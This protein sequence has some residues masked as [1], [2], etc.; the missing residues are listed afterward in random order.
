MIVIPNRGRILAVMLALALA[1]GLLTLTLLAKPTQA[2]P[3]TDNENRGAG[4]HRDAIGFVID[5]TDCTGEL[6]QLTGTLHTADQFFETDGGYHF[7][8]HSNLSNVKGVGLDPQTLEPTGTE[9]TITAASGI[10]ENF[11]P[12]G[13]TV[14]GTMDSQVVIGKG[15]ADDQVA[16]SQVHYI[17]EF[18]DGEPTVKVETI[19]VNFDCH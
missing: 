14:S 3:P 5:T 12:T 19:H 10:A 4:T 9:Y 7:S 17:V 1:G 2:Q 6:I 11:V 18:V 16:T 13:S 8:I 15:Q